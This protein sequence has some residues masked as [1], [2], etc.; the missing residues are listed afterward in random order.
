MSKE[1]LLMTGDTIG[2]L[3]RFLQCLDEMDAK[4]RAVEI[5]GKKNNELLKDP[6][7]TAALEEMRKI[8]TAIDTI[9]VAFNEDAG[10]RLEAV[11]G[12]EREEREAARN[13]SGLMQGGI[14]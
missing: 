5:A 7:M 11:I 3:Q 1:F 10:Q 12:M 2:R 9:R 8:R 6:T 4:A 14:K 13:I